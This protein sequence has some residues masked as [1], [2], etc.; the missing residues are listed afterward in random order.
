[1]LSIMLSQ[2]HPSPGYHLVRVKCAF[3]ELE[4]GGS[5]EFVASYRDEIMTLLKTTEKEQKP[6]VRATA[7][8]QSD[9][10][11]NS[12]ATFGEYMT[13]FRKKITDVDRILISGHFLQ[14]QSSGKV[15][16]TAAANQL[17]REQGVKVGNPSMS[18][19]RNLEAKRIFVVGKG[20]Y[21]VSQSGM[22]YLD[23]LKGTQE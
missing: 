16:A 10:A 11:E 1:M 8:S 7:V 14:S 2:D 17:L 3:G 6:L 20:N 5:L 22:E 4:V 12:D 19:R 23:S 18:V 21:R 15:F 13:S 9:I